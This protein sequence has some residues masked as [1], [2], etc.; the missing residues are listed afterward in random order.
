MHPYRVDTQ[1][2][3]AHGIA[4]LITLLIAMTFGIAISL[5]FFLPDLLGD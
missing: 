5:Q 1:L 4:A 3:Y 2:V